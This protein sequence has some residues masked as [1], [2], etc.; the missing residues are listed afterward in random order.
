MIH[1][2]SAFAEVLFFPESALRDG[3]NVPGKP[4]PPATTVANRQVHSALVV[5]AEPGEVLAA[6]GLVTERR[7]LALQVV[8]ADCVPV[9]IAGPRSVAAVHAGWR[10]LAGGIL[11]N[12]LPQLGEGRGEATAWI[13]PAIGP[14]CYEVGFPVAQAIARLSGTE[15]VLPPPGAPHGR[16]HLDLPLAALRQL[17]SLG[18][19][20]VRLTRLCTF[21]GD[22]KG[23]SSYRRDGPG[24]GRNRALIWRGRG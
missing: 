13:G 23:W 1:C 16:P 8:T 7:D 22:G 14:C 21:C 17:E 24:A 9:L 6:D 10:G 5:E 20:D 2:Q 19:A 15:C 3:Q 12:T 11:A 4:E 18:V